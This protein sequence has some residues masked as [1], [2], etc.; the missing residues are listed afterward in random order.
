MQKQSLTPTDIIDYLTQHK[1]FFLHHPEILDE[2][3]LHHTQ[4]NTLSLVEM[5]LDRQRHRIQ[6]LEAELEK[7]TQLAIQNSDIFLGLLPLQQQLS[8]AHNL[9][10]GIQKLDQWVKK[11]ELQQAKILLFTGCVAER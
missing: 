7:F 5:Q 4:N 1:D 3:N 10:E 2:L 9:T 11:F 6:E 8:Q